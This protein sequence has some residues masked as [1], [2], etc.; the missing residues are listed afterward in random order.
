MI[1]WSDRDHW[2]LCILSIECYMDTGLSCGDLHTASHIL[3]AEDDTIFEGDERTECDRSLEYDTSCE[4]D[5]IIKNSFPLYYESLSGHEEHI[6]YTLVFR[7][8]T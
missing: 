2:G 4:G 8:Y 1:D 6:E 7:R 3:V 5:Y